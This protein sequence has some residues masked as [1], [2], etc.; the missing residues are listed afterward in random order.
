MTTSRM[1]SLTC[2]THSPTAARLR[3]RERESTEPHSRARLPAMTTA[4]ASRCAA[5]PARRAVDDCPVCGRP[6]CGSDAV[7]FGRSGCPACATSAVEAPA[8]GWAELL[9]RAGLA[10][11]AVALVGGW[12]G[13]QYARNRGFSLIAPALVGM[14]AAWATAAATEG[15]NAGRRVVTG[16]AAVG[17]LLSAALAFR[18]Y[19]A[20]GLS[21]W[22]PAG[23]VLPPYV[24]AVVG[25][26]AW[27]VLFGP[28]KRPRSPEA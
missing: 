17:A 14:G 12:I 21:P 6:R 18:V 23:R 9:V 27:P 22:H 13:T 19:A 7:N 24:A 28:P 10:A 3:W 16:I 25:V 4:T 2:L 15:G 5:H 8:A 1:S 26:L 11:M 20:G